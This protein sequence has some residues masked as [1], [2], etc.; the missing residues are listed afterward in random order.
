MSPRLAA[1]RSQDDGGD[2][3]W[4]RGPRKNSN[5]TAAQHLRDGGF[6]A[7]MQMKE[8]QYSCRYTAHR[9]GHRIFDQRRIDQ[10]IFTAAALITRSSRRGPPRHRRRG[11]C[12]R[13]TCRPRLTSSGKSAGLSRIPPAFARAGRTTR[14]AATQNPSNS[15][16]RKRVTASQGRRLT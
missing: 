2:A 11:T 14:R 9:S 16:A 6:I 15:R 13:G 7:S 3:R 8:V 5:D 4:C 10:P 12:P 1:I